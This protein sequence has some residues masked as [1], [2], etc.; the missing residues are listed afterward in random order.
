MGYEYVCSAG[1]SL[2]CDQD[3]ETYAALSSSGYVYC[4]VAE[5]GS[6][7]SRTLGQLQAVDIADNWIVVTDFG[8]PNSIEQDFSYESI[9]GDVAAVAEYVHSQGAALIGVGLYVCEWISAEEAQTYNE[10]IAGLSDGYVDMSYIT[11]TI[12]GMHLPQSGVDLMSASI[13]DATLSLGNSGAQPSSDNSQTEIALD[14]SSI[15][16]MFSAA[17]GYPASTTASATATPD[18]TTDPFGILNQYQSGA[19]AIV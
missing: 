3:G 5:A 2:M 19:L 9:A 13:V 16:S 11:E 6:N 4:S 14:F 8:L 1:S 7:S 18:A 10:I 15:F 12:D 17:I